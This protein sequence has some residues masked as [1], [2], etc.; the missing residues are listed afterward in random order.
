VV[1]V[2]HNILI[3]QSSKNHKLHATH[4]NFQSRIHH[5]PLITTGSKCC[6]PEA[7]RFI[8]LSNGDGYCQ[9][10]FESLWALQFVMVSTGTTQGWNSI[11]SRKVSD[12]LGH[13]LR[14]L[15]IGVI[16][17]LG[18]RKFESLRT[19]FDQRVEKS[20]EDEL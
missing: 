17:L 20:L 18:I 6:A 9:S 3:D 2:L 7:Q 11:F 1:I 4:P 15:C 13:V 14:L 16:L 8:I 19:T 5:E 10:G 12:I